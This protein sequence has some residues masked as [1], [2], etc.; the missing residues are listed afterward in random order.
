VSADE[1]R[2]DAVAAIYLAAK[3][4]GAAAFK[5]ADVAALTRGNVTAEDLIAAEA[6]L[7]K[8]LQWRT[9]APT[10]AVA[11]HDAV[12][13]H[14]V[15]VSVADEVSAFA[16]VARTS[17]AVWK[18]TS[19]SGA[20]NSSRS[21]FSA[22]TWPSWLGR[23]VRNRHRHAIEQA[24]RRWRGGR[25]DDSARPRRELLISTQVLRARRRASD[26]SRGGLR[27][28]GVARRARG[29]R[30]GLRTRHALGRLAVAAPERRSFPARGARQA[31]RCAR[32]RHV[33]AG[34]DARRLRDG[35][36]RP[37]DAVTLTLLEALSCPTST[38]IL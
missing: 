21:H 26:S 6:D 36:A 24:S 5:A 33:R 25:R 9:H 20:D 2:R 27:R 12:T 22:M 35:H 37:A 13:F 31:G 15:D 7:V 4:E 28:R 19:V 11:I 23:A 3:V 10:V 34:G 8:T 17:Y 18:S 32:A 29:R 38:T 1:F 30:S 16:R 14:A